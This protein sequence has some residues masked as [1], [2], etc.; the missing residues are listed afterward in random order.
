M[1]GGMK[2]PPS[3]SHQEILHAYE[4]QLGQ[5]RGLAPVTCRHR[6]R[7]V[8]RFLQAARVRRIGD[9]AQLG[10][11]RLV[12]Y[13]ATQSAHY[14]PDSLRNVASSVR[15]F[16]RFA[17][18][19]GWTSGSQELGVPKI[20]NRGPNDLPV[21]LSVQQL[22]SLLAGWDR[23]TPEGARDS[24]IGL[25]LAK[26]GLRAGEVAAL[27]LEDINWRQASM[28]L[29]RSKGG[30]SAQVP[31]LAE[32]GK[33]I[34]HYLRVGR[35]PCA[36]RQVFLFCQTARPMSAQAVSAVVRRGLRRCGIEVRRAGAHLLRHTL[37][38]HLVQNG[39]SL[40]EVADVLRHRELNSASVYAHVDL[41]NL[42]SVAQPWPQE[43]RL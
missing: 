37:A 23:R 36:H 43:V 1:M 24:A 26:L 3:K 2:K 28:R 5:V 32:V 33:A 6:L 42:R 35:P 17:R 25:C 31:L 41:A 34:A 40:K 29:G 15:D 9:L 30:Q 4:R 20:A 8:R 21:Y 11:A 14:Q 18:Q 27:V 19:Q 16:L 39:A 12:S 7:D 10:P 38:T 13:L 22:K